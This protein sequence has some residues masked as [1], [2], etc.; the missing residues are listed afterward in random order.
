MK[1]NKIALSLLLSTSL[2]A[3]TFN[4]STT[5]ELR[6]ALTT[7]A[8][9]GED[10]TIILADGIYKTT[11]DGEGTFIYNSNEGEDLYAISEGYL[12]FF[13]GFNLTLIGSNSK[14][15]ILSGDHR[16]QI[17]NF[18]TTDKSYPRLKFEKMRFIDAN[19]TNKTGGGAI[20]TNTYIELTDCNIS[21]NH[22]KTNGGGVYTIGDAII[23][24]TVF[25]NN[26]AQYDG[27]GLYIINDN[28]YNY[29]YTS[30]SHNYYSKEFYL[31]YGGVE[32]EYHQLGV[33]IYNSI[34]DNNSAINKGGGFYS[35]STYNDGLSVIQNSIFLENNASDAGAFYTTNVQ[36]SNLLLKNN[37]NGIYL[38]SGESSIIINSI[39]DNNATEINGTISYLN[40]NYIDS[41]K[42]QNVKSTNNNIFEGI[43]LGFLS[44]EHNNFA[45][46]ESSDLINTGIKDFSDITSFQTEIFFNNDIGSVLGTDINGTKR[47]IDNYIDIGPYEFS[48]TKPVINNIDYFGYPEEGT[49]L[50]FI[51]DYTLVNGRNI[52]S[53]SYDYEDNGIFSTKNTHIFNTA[54]SYTINVKV[55]DSSGEFT[56]QS[57][58][59]L[60]KSSSIEA[61]SFEEMGDD[62]KLV[63]AIDPAYY[64]AII[65]IIND[66]KAIANDEG[67][68]IGLNNGKQ[69]VKDNPTEFNLT[70][71]ADKAQAV[72]DANNSAYASGK[73]LVIDTPS[74][75]G[76]NVIKPLTEDDITNLP[77]GWSMIA[78]PTAITNLSIFNSAKIIWQMKDNVWS[79]YSSNTTTTSALND[80]N[81]SQLTSLPANSAIWVVK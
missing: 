73:Q 34:F 1:N 19:N 69:Y 71:L 13:Q 4:V 80:A 46:T 27:G 78:I 54:G 74:D 39:F 15:V 17:I 51:T 60:I 66:Q 56:T 75:F 40:N 18:Q 11:D 77:T 58:N 6:E 81:I 76:I 30:Y 59:I 44:V 14:K 33:R 37:N 22:S 31:D 67:Y 62:Q 21:N 61:I 23:K 53:V 41:K 57:K 3:Q 25:M 35:A 63:K 5:P 47:I 32:N 38:D 68:E 9:N 72:A 20:Y 79:A 55:L 2:L 16:H 48:N 43:N 65:Q 70:T 36:G 10:D 49:N 26:T 12:N 42:I 8:T 7:A 28:H 50:E 24:N 64:E 45:L 29:D 52:S